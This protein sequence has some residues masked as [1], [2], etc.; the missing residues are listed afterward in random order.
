MQLPIYFDYAATTPVDPRV[1]EKMIQY[2]TPDGAF[3]N[4][5]SSSHR[6]GWA[7]ENAVNEARAHVAALLNADPKEIV[8]TSG[9]TES[10]NLA[11]KGV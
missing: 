10:D 4:P 7:A 2:L 5:A 6:F 8:F 3:G 1:A 9:A 11:I